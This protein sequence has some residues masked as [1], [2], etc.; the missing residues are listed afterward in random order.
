MIALKVSVDVAE[1]FRNAIVSFLV[2]YVC[3]TSSLNVCCDASLKTLGISSLRPSF[4]DAKEPS[5]ALPCESS[6]NLSKHLR[7]F[8]HRSSINSVAMEEFSSQIV[9]VLMGKVPKTS[10][11][12]ASTQR[13][14]L[15]EEMR[16]QTVSYRSEADRQGAELTFAGSV[17][18][19]PTLN[20]GARRQP[21]G[22]EPLGTIVAPTKATPHRM[23]WRYIRKNAH[24]MRQMQHLKL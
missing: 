19:G 23:I 17:G 10:S 9:D 7:V 5:S 8:G 14:L 12:V 22:R 3:E 13:V 18:A 1:S 16:V 20:V 2:S 15:A 24:P 6:T 4:S 11:Q 21:G